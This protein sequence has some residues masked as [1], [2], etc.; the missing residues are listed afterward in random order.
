MLTRKDGEVV[1]QELVTVT[2]NGRRVVRVSK[3]V[4][5]AAGRHESRDSQ[6]EW[7]SWQVLF[8]G[9]NVS[10]WER[11][12]AFAGRDGELV[13]ASPGEYAKSRHEYGDF[14]L[15]FEWRVSPGGNGGVHYR[16]QK[17]VSNQ[18]WAG[19]EFQIVDNERHPN[20]RNPLTSA[21]AL[22]GLIPPN[23]DVTHPAGQFNSSR[24]VC[25]GSR[26]E[27]WINGS[28]VLKYDLDSDAYQW[29]REK[30]RSGYI[31]LQ[32]NKGEIAFRN[33]RIR[34][35]RGETASSPAVSPRPAIA[36]L[37]AKQADRKAAEYVRSLGGTVRTEDDPF[38]V[39]SVELEH[40]RGVTDDGLAVF[41]ECKNVTS[42]NLRWNN[43][44]DKA[45]EH[46]LNCRDLEMLQLGPATTDA[47]LKYLPKF[48]NLKSLNLTARAGQ[49]SIEGLR[50]L[51]ECKN[52]TH[53]TLTWS[54]LTDETV[55]EV[56]N[57]PHLTSLSL[58]ETKAL[59]DEGL[60]KLKDC[61]HLRSLSIT[62]TNLISDRMLNELRAALPECEVTISR[63][64]P[65]GRWAP[66]LANEA[67]LRSGRSKATTAAKWS[68]KTGG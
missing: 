47:A 38:R 59:T 66:L 33:I 16:E 7:S 55:G 39:V 46:F 18:K 63:Y 28:L 30:A 50:N 5:A 49:I 25:R 22:Y 14:E 36:P 23:A 48:P 34:E 15:E 61:R 8:D 64:L 54:A 26:V 52:L 35:C 68:L 67:I 10:R 65:P 21:G 9:T 13:A 27:H 31:Y 51:R 53:A 32:A 62:K 42:L 58:P 60:A 4:G 37:G 24:I 3:E 43:A 20:G 2:R 11:L 1:R 45:L 19:N 40:R 29:A 6:A 44:T 17:S 56:K 41:R 12:G 57:W